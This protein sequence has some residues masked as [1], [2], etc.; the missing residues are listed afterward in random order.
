VKL[1]ALL[2]HVTNKLADGQAEERTGLLHELAGATV[3][4][5]AC[6]KFYDLAHIYIDEDKAMYCYVC[7]AVHNL[8]RAVHH[9]WMSVLSVQEMLNDAAKK[10]S[11]EP[12]DEQPAKYDE[13][14]TTKPFD[15]ERACN[16][17]APQRP[18]REAQHRASR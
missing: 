3:T 18:R 5:D 10:I 2:V 15:D 4:C 13:I 1:K 6:E 7:W 11:D 16:E 17:T 12:M 14:S 8:S 9:D